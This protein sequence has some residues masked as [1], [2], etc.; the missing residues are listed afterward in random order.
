MSARS[1][2]FTVLKTKTQKHISTQMRIICGLSLLECLIVVSL[3]ATL[4]FSS[5]FAYQQ[6]VTR[7]QLII[8]T[9]HFIDAL[10][11]ARM[12]AITHDTTVTF[13]PRSQSYATCGADW[14]QGI[15]I[16]NQKNQQVFRV[17]SAV[18]KN[19]HIYWK[20]T[21]GESDNLRWRANGFTRGQ[22]G[23]FL[24]CGGYHALS[25]QLIILRTGRIRSVIGKISACDD[26]SN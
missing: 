16:L 2:A 10:R 3:I 25:A 1:I 17:L 22:Q 21:L 19:D 18:P 23:S 11:Y 4:I 15:L 6:W 9:N 26:P 7:N 8:L 5:V 12:M 13:C 14:R 24:I 20:S